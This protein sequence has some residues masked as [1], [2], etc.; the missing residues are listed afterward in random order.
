[1]IPNLSF[2]QAENF[3]NSIGIL[4]QSA[5]PSKFSGPQTPLQQEGEGMY[6]TLE[7]MQDT[8]F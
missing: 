4:Q 5:T 6:L 3:C 2:Q 8:I 1:L 7:V